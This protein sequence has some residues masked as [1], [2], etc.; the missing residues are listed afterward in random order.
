MLYAF[1]FMIQM[2]Q[3]I[4]KKEFGVTDKYNTTILLLIITFK[5]F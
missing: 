4:L 5:I 3:L 1:F 2:I